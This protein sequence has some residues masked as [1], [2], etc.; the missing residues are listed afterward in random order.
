MAADGE[1][2]IAC[3]EMPEEGKHRFQLMAEG[4]ELCFSCHDEDSFAGKTVHGPVAKGECIKCHNPHA[5]DQERMLRKT[6]PDL[7]FDCHKR[8]LKD[9]KGKVLPSPKRT[10]EDEE[11]KLHP[12]FAEGE[13]L[14][15]HNPHASPNYR[16]LA[17]FYPEGLYAN[18]SKNEYVCFNCHGDDAFIE[19]RT[20][21]ETNFRNGNLN[22]HYR[23]VN[24]K[25]GRSCKACHHHHGTQNEKLIRERTPFG[26]RHINIRD[27]SR[28]ETGGTCAPTCHR[29]VSY[30]RFEPVLNSLRVTPR[31]GVDATPAELERARKEELGQ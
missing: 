24:R 27:F 9:A 10:F 28:S 16:L 25:K 6:I 30:D 13:C 15:C 2:C 1:M 4:A 5:S 20:L 7:C 21:E 14:Y 26:G 19:P 18:F 23:H 11:M 12:P 3:H 8:A 29:Q 31:E 22:L 17:G